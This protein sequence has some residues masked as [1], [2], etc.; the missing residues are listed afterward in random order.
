MCMY[1]IIFAYFSRIILFSYSITVN[2][3]YFKLDIRLFSL[4][5]FRNFIRYRNKEKSAVTRFRS[6]GHYFHNRTDLYGSIY[7]NESDRIRIKTG[8]ICTRQYL[9][10]IEA[11][12]R[13][14]A[15]R[16]KQVILIGIAEMA[17]CLF[18]CDASARGSIDK[19]D[20]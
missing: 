6:I 2:L 15:V 4:W 11:Q 19:A 1:D 17:I 8:R 5:L 3:S 16:R 9:S 12:R 18:G 13:L 7:C 14:I 20:L 10:H